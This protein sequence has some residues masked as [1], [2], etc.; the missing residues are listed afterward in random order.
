MWYSYGGMVTRADALAE[1]IRIKKY[2]K[3]QKLLKGPYYV[4]VES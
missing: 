2:C 4:T 3:K 1:Q